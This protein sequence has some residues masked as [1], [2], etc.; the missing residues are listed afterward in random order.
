MHCQ[1]PGNSSDLF[2]VGTNHE[3]ELEITLGGAQN[4]DRSCAT[5]VSNSEFYCCVIYLVPYIIRLRKLVDPAFP[6]CSV[7]ELS[8]QS[9]T[10]VP[11]SKELL[12]R[13]S[14]RTLVPLI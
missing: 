3:Y 9:R 11:A 4:D 14:H 2:V 6:S 5:S 13:C 8:P 7:E 1:F 12:Q 10:D